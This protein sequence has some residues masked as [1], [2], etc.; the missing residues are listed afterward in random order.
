MPLMK[1]FTYSQT[2][3]TCLQSHPT[4]PLQTSSLQLKVTTTGKAAKTHSALKGQTGGL[5]EEGPVYGD[6][7]QP[8]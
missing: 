8:H 4:L 7:G 5:S 3:P 1:A 2:P 6:S